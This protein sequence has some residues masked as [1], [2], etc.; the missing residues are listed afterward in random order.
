MALYRGQ[1]Q[2]GGVSWKRV[3][4]HMGGTRSYQQCRMRWQFTLIFADSGLM[5]EGA[6]T[7]DEVS[8]IHATIMYGLDCFCNVCIALYNRHVLYTV[9]IL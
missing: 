7:E 3:S 1:G 5:K 8:L 4:S 9:S 6:W 2:G